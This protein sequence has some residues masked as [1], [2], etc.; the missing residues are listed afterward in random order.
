MLMYNHVCV[1]LIMI[2]YDYVWVG[3][4]MTSANRF[5]LAISGFSLIYINVNNVNNC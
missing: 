1:G 4:V 5:F 3:L 2:M